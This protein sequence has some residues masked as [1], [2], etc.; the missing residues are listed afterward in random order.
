MSLAKKSGELEAFND[1]QKA[2][3]SMN[4]A[5]KEPLVKYEHIYSSPWTGSYQTEK[6]HKELVEKIKSWLRHNQNDSTPDDVLVTLGFFIIALNTEYLTLQNKNR[7]ESM[8]VRYFNILRAY[9]NK[10]YNNGPKAIQKLAGF[11]PIISYARE[12]AEILKGRLPV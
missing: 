11:M 8:Q 1:V 3:E 10:K 5:D 7:V 9:L 2:L 6:R 12:G 4:L